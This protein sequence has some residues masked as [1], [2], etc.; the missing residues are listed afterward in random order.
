MADLPEV[1]LITL[2]SVHMA[3][4]EETEEAV[5]TAQRIDESE[6][7]AFAARQKT[8]NI[9]AAIVALRGHTMSVLDTELEK[10]RNQFGCG[11]AAEQLEL[12]MRRMVKSLLHT[13]TIRA[14]QM[15]AQGRTDEYV[16]GLEALYGIEVEED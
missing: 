3:A 1:E 9:D 7:Q 12:A 6:M 16:A 4:P 15:A 2:E 14:K 11:A 5:A 8:R 13:S 10:V